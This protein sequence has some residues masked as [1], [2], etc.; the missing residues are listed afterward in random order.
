MLLFNLKYRSWVVLTLVIALVIFLITSLLIISSKIYNNF[1]VLGYIS[2]IVSIL[3]ILFILFGSILG[4]I[5]YVYPEHVVTK[6]GIKTVA[7]VQATVDVEVYYYP[8]KNLIAMD[9]TYIVHESYGSGS[10]DPFKR[11]IMPI[12][13]EVEN[14]K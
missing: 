1:K 3:L 4:I 8:Y 6:N 7:Q 2:I 10:Y 12:P 13:L 9:S 5:F 14:I 11:D